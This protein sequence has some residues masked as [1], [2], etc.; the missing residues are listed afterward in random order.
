MFTKVYCDGTPLNT[1]S[2]KPSALH[3]R[4][5]R[6]TNYMG[7]CECKKNK[8]KANLGLKRSLYTDHYEEDVPDEEAGTSGSAAGSAERRMLVLRR[9]VDLGRRR[10]RLPRLDVTVQ[11]PLLFVDERMD[12]DRRYFHGILFQVQL[13]LAPFR[14]NRQ[15]QVLDVRTNA[16]TH[17]QKERTY[18][19]LLKFRS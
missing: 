7:Y 13:R 4:V 12:V 17:T 11:F 16:H 18:S 1:P 19:G 5:Y 8:L 14:R 9:L 2:H 3:G 15:R 10:R 6:Q